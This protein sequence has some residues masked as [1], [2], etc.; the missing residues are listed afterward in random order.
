MF[1]TKPV[2]AQTRQSCKYC[3]LIGCRESSVRESNAAKRDEVGDVASEEAKSQQ[4]SGKVFQKLNS[5]HGDTGDNLRD[6][7]HSSTK[8]AML[9]MSPPNNLLGQGALKPN[10][11]S[12]D[13]VGN[14]TNEKAKLQES[15]AKVS[16]KPLLRSSS[17]SPVKVENSAQKSKPQLCK[18]NR[19]LRRR[20]TKVGIQSSG[21]DDAACHRKSNLQNSPVKASRKPVLN[22]TAEKSNVDDA[23]CSKKAKLRQSRSKVLR[24]PVLNLE[25]KILMFL[26]IQHAT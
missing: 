6:S 18:T 21:D 16:Q 23:T 22:S 13:E 1:V 8:K 9:K 4:S 7:A 11:H 20:V 12:C 2:A 10:T 5:H 24:E 19:V 3:P 15:P 25:A 14:T 26:T 17:E